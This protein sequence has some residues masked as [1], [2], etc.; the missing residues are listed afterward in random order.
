[1]TII[2]MNCKKT[3]TISVLKGELLSKELMVS[4]MLDGDCTQF[5]FLEMIGVPKEEIEQIK[6]QLGEKDTN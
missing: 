3:R 1:M 5:E 4:K 6:K 2:L